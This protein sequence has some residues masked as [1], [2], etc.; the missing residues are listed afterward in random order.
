[1]TEYADR[2]KGMTDAELSAEWVA[3]MTARVET[4]NRE[5]QLDAI[6]AVAEEVN[7]RYARTSFTSLVITPK[8]AL[9]VTEHLKRWIGAVDSDWFGPEHDEDD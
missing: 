7:A 9:A 2:L 1:M 5:A 3:V 8:D 4:D 6:D